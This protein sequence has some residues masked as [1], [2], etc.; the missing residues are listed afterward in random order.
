MQ[1]VNR[2]QVGFDYHRA[3]S[4]VAILIGNNIL[5][6]TW[7]VMT[8]VTMVPQEVLVYLRNIVKVTMVGNAEHSRLW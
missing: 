2:Y 7:N 5:Q 4:I 1:A 3:Q 8:S 6:V